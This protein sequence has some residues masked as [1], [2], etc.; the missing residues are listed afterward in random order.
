MYDCMKRATQHQKFV[1]E[2]ARRWWQVR[3]Q[4]LC[5]GKCKEGKVKRDG[6]QLTMTEQL[7]IS[8]FLPILL[9]IF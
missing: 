5:T 4:M 3:R 2:E 9:R 7:R 8:N 6:D 1:A